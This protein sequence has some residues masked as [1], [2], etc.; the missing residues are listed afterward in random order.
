MGPLGTRIFRGDRLKAARE[1]M[2]KSQSRLA[3]EIG[4]HV[5]SVSDWER[6]KNAPS[7]RYV[8]ALCANL[9]V[10]PEYLYGEDDDEEASSLALS[11]DEHRLFF[12][13]LGKAL[14]VKERA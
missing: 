12:D 14:G 5:T 6:N 4:A 13:L 10:T 8:A 3:R 11:R 7:G 9:A 1:A 2:R